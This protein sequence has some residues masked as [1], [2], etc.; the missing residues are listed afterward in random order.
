[1]KR[2]NEART[3]IRARMSVVPFACAIVLAMALGA[4]ISAASAQEPTLEPGAPR[5]W[6]G[7][8]VSDSGLID[9]RGNPFFNGYPRVT[10]V[11]RGSP[12]DLAGVRPGDVLVTFNSHDMKGN[13]LA[14]R[15]LLEPGMNFVVRLRRGEATREVRG[16]IGPR[17]PGF[18]ERVVLIWRGEGQEPGSGISSVTT[19]NVQANVRTG[20]PVRVT[21]RTWSP[22][23][24]GLPPVLLPMFAYGDGVYPFAGA[25]F[26]ALNADLGKALGVKREGVLVTN[27]EPGSP[28]NLA[29]LRGGD[30][31]LTA[32]STR[33]ASP[34][35]LVR[36]I[37]EAGDR[38]IRLGIVRNRKAKT[39][40]LRW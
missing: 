23:P 22:M 17:P 33:L 8:T 35:A 2:N 36:A 10:S 15:D 5:G 28:A 14:L 39:L 38:S 19:P 32:D 4:C 34:I 18:G 25:E 9:E 21:V 29:G 31:V 16:V 6:F 24:V 13:S 11:E 26:T 1:M 30:V 40:M 12:A 27:V 3:S 20:G 37:R 7:V